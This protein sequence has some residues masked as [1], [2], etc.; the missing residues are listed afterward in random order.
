MRQIFA[1]F[2][3]R[4]DSISF[5]YNS[6]TEG[7][8]LEIDTCSFFKISTLLQYI[9]LLINCVCID[10]DVVLTLFRVFGQLWCSNSDLSWKFS[11]VSCQ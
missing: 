7:K 2:P 6:P 4:G 8:C 5:P 11:L 10:T 1:L 9:Y 3:A